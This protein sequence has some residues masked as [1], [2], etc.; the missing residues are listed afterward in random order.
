MYIVDCRRL[1]V[2][3]INIELFLIKDKV[4]YYYLYYLFDGIFNEMGVLDLDYYLWFKLVVLVCKCYICI[5]FYIK[6]Y[7]WKY[8]EYIYLG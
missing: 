2:D 5:F 4:K 6:V 8:C 1:F 7:E 3:I